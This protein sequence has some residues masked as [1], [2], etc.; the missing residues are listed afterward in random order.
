[1]KSLEEIIEHVK[2][3][4]EKLR[5][6]IAAGIDNGYNIVLVH[7]TGP[8][9]LQKPNLLGVTNPEFYNARRYK[10]KILAEFDS[11]PGQYTYGVMLG[12]Q[13]GGFYLICIE[14]DIDNECK[15]IA[16][17]RIEE[18]LRKHGIHY[19]LESTNEGRYHIFINLDKLSEVIKKTTKLNI[20]CDAIKYVGGKP[21]KGEIRILGTDGPHLRTV[22][23]GITNNWKPFYGKI[24]KFL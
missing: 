13:P 1:M 23:N 3:N 2:S 10:D 8:G 14:I 9:A 18:K 11:K 24:S 19:Y 21:V 6:Y 15:E 5:S 17:Q 22:Y 20:N 4:H 7:L 12:K 16:R